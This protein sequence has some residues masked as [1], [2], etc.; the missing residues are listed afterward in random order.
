[1]KQ[2]AR[3]LTMITLLFITQAHGGPKVTG[4]SGSITVD[5]H[6]GVTMGFVWIK[7]GTFLMGSPLTEA[8]RQADEGPTHEV[9]IT[10]G[11]YLAE[12]EIT[13]AQW[14]AVMGTAP[15]TGRSNVEA[16]PGHPAVYVSWIDMQEFLRR[17][18]EE[19]EEEMYR[20]PTEAEWEYACRAGTTT[21][22]SFGDDSSRLRDYACYLGSGATE[23]PKFA[24]PVAK[25]RP[26]PWGLYDMHGNVWEWVQDEYRPDA[27]SGESS[28]DGAATAEGSK[29][30][31]RGG[32][33][34]NQGRHLRSARRFS[35]DPSLRYCALGARLVKTR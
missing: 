23:G 9:E 33:F 16:D 10:K 29:R 17:L 5:L 28:E 7:P 18:N 2:L 8:D 20:L 34:V 25:R 6:G 31:M 11:F 13:Q 4:D 19:A 21:K 35:F 26:N 22:W 30:V 3:S 14:V 12:C 15:W 32:G 1:M 27:Y 24:Q